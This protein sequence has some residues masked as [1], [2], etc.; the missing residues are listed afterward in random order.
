MSKNFKFIHCVDFR[1]INLFNWVVTSEQKMFFILFLYIKM[2]CSIYKETFEWNI[3]EKMLFIFEQ[4]STLLIL[5]MTLWL[6]MMRC[7]KLIWWDKILFL[8]FLFRIYYQ[9]WRHQ[10]VK[11]IVLHLIDRTIFTLLIM[12]II[13]YK[14]LIYRIKFDY[15][16]VNS[17]SRQTIIFFSFFVK[18]RIK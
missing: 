13:E 14:N 15:V 11:L 8:S 5:I 4:D 9:T 3:Y 18:K 12:T 16:I 10:L 1:L 7:H 17:Y 6:K 2:V